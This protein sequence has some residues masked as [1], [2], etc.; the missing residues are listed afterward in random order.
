MPLVRVTSSAK[1]PSGPALNALFTELSRAAAELFG[2][3]E[4]WVMTC[5]DP[6]ATMT[7]GSSSEPAAYIEVKNIGALSPELAVRVS[8]TITEIVAK[9]FGVPTDRI[10]IEMTEADAVRWG[11]DGSTFG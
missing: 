1:T 10:Y 4:R 8:K 9:G 2:K 7:F 6:V 5:L 11:Y 3:P